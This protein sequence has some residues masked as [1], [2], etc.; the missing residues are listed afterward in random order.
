MEKWNMINPASRTCGRMKPTRLWM[1]CEYKLNVTECYQEGYT[2][3]YEWLESE[4]NVTE[5]E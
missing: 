4:L 1:T 5:P 2:W 3:I